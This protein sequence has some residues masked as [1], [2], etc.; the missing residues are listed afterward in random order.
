MVYNSKT[1][2]KGI[3][4]P[5]N[6]KKYATGDVNNIIYRSNL[7]RRFFKILD[8]NPNIVMWAS[9]EFSIPYVSPIDNRT[10]RYFVD[11]LVKTTKNEI[12]VIEIKP[13][14][15]TQEPKKGNK[16]KKTFLTEAVN[17]AINQAKWKSPKKFCEEKGWKFKIVT[18]RD[19]LSVK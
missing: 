12:F 3:F 8:E 4:R 6:P 19:L 2:R 11:L 15:Y 1:I 14:A 18:E 9:E 7:E 17:Y 10:H 13:Y 16:S 5:V